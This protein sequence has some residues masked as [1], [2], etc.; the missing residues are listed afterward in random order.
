MKNIIFEILILLIKANIIE[1]ILTKVC[2]PICIICILS[3]ITMYSFL[4]FKF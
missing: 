4:G 3:N 2:L 1:F